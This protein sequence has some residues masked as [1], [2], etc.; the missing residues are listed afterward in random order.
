MPLR[1]YGAIYLENDSPLTRLLGGLSEGASQGI[2]LGIQKGQKVTDMANEVLM[3]VTTGK[4]DPRLLVSDAGQAFLKSAGLDKHPGIQDVVT[5]AGASLPPE[6]AVKPVPQ[7]QP[8][9]IPSKTPGAPPYAGAV[10][11]AENPPAKGI[12]DLVYN[13]GISKKL[14]YEDKKRSI[15]SLYAIQLALT[16]DELAQ[17]HR[18]DPDKLIP[19][20]QS[21]AQ[22][23]GVPM[24]DVLVTGN[25]NGLFSFTLKTPDPDKAIARSDRLKTKED[26]FNT[27]VAETITKKNSYGFRLGTILSTDVA[28]PEIAEMFKDDPKMAAAWAGAMSAIKSSSGSKN[29][30]LDKVATVERFIGQINDEIRAWNERNTRE[31]EQAGL[32]PNTISAKQVS[33]L[34]FEDVSGGMKKED[35]IKKKLP[36]DAKDLISQARDTYQRSGIVSPQVRAGKAETDS[37]KVRRV[38]DDLKKVATEAWADRPGLTSQELRDTIMANK[39]GLMAEYGLN[40]RLFD[41]V[42]K[43]ADT[44]LR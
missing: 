29:Y 43:M 11:T 5:N 8:I 42:V 25:S 12:Q 39:E 34:T 17:G 4:L 23:M 36:A 3:A 30:V 38:Y 28:A 1:N 18:I 14:A 26:T 16:K 24:T 6:L 31:G 21:F 13:E 32:S 22:A 19:K 7:E 41:L 35:W 15:D 10:S 40:A 27:H 44:V 9:P 2:K 20:I 33:E 37:E